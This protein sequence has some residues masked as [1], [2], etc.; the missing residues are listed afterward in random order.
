MS[1]TPNPIET[2]R[3]DLYPEHDLFFCDVADAVLK[4]LT[5]Q[6]EHPFYALSKKPSRGPITYT[7]EPTGKWVEISCDHHGQATIYDKDILIYCISQLVSKMNR[8][9]KPSPR[10]RLNAIDLLRFTN[11]GTGGKDYEAL[12][13]AVYRL[14]GTKIK[15][16]IGH[17]DN[18]PDCEPG[19]GESGIYGYNLINDYTIMRKN[20][21]EGRIIWIEFTL[22]NWV[23]AGISPKSIL[24]LHRDYFR[25][26]KPLE[27]RIYEMA[28][29]M[30]G[31]DNSRPYELETLFI[32]SGSRGTLREFRRK[33]KEMAKGNH[34]PDYM[35][36]FDDVSDKVRFVNRGT[37]NS[38][39]QR[40]MIGMLPA[41]TYEK[42]RQAAPG[43]DVY[44][45]EEQWRAAFE[46]APRD[47]SAAFVGFCK[48]V[49]EHRGAA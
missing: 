32:R 25:L 30:V 14:A 4:D 7:H 8:G 10:V 41:V 23:F 11:R 1:D 17:P 15:T 36:E 13:E 44:A 26:R 48:R 35:I 6:M 27:R 49:R 19:F 42:A 45:L 2:L 40:A 18:R 37:M 46:E 24:T 28:R 34:L 47:A 20:G 33:I 16:N 3:P 39:K 43:Y 22:A 5:A 12:K 29:K 31:N 21:N 38:R 9:V